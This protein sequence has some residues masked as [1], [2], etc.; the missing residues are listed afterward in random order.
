MACSF[1]LGLAIRGSRLF[2]S[3]RM[4]MLVSV[5]IRSRAALLPKDALA[6]RGIIG[7]KEDADLAFIKCVGQ[8]LDGLGGARRLVELCGKK[9]VSEEIDAHSEIGGPEDP[10]DC[11]GYSGLEYA[12]V[13]SQSD[14]QLR[15]RIVF[16]R[17]VDQALLEILCAFQVGGEDHDLAAG[18]GDEVGFSFIVAR[19]LQEPCPMGVEATEPCQGESQSSSCHP[20]LPTPGG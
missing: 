20:R 7:V 5:F 3:D 15:E 12:R 11:L 19:C 14:L 4:L 8:L 6:G 2:W 17:L 10:C 1:P 16:K 18:R 9:A 13:A